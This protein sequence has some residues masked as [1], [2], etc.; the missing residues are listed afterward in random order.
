MLIS[1]Y[2]PD[3]N[4][5]V[6]CHVYDKVRI[7]HQ[8]S[9]LTLSFPHLPDCAKALS[10]SCWIRWGPIG[11]FKV[12]GSDLASCSWE[13]CTRYFS[14]ASLARL[15][16]LEVCKPL[17]NRERQ[18]R[19][20]TLIHEVAMDVF[21]YGFKET[22]SH[23]LLQSKHR[24]SFG[25]NEM[26]LTGVAVHCVWRHSKADTQCLGKT[27]KQPCSSFWANG[28]LKIWAL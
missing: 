24:C 21:L 19:K 17:R 1:H 8:L 5:W 28:A 9:L 3:A 22:W 16:Y 2:G 23:R 15:S 25:W 27:L 26:V 6:A 18:F 20:Q 13:L 10:N 12:F 14:P 7:K 11:G 4:N